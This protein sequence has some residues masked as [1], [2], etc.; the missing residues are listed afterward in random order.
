M[1]FARGK[2]LLKNPKKYVGAKL[3][4]YRSSWEWHFMSMCDTHPN[5][6]N[7]SSEGIKIPYLCPLSNRPTVYVPDFLI[8][9]IDKTG[10]KHVEIIEIKPRSQTM[11]EHVGRSL[12]NQ[13]QY[14]RNQAKWQAANTWCQQRGVN[15]R[16]INEQDMFHNGRPGKKK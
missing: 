8:S 6:E 2:Y 1:N 11:K 4:I 3:P 9:Y 12:H 15:F 14:V 5:I 16:I 7:W 13:S 10:K